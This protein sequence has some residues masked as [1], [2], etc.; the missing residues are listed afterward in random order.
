VHHQLKVDSRE[1]AELFPRMVWHND[2]PLDFANSVQIYA[3]SK[4]AKERV[5][6]VLTGE[7]SDELFGGYPRYRIPDL[8]NMVRYVP[9]PLRRLT[10]SLGDHRVKKLAR[11][12]AVTPDEAILYNASYLRPEVVA[13]VLGR[14]LPAALEYRHE[15]LKATEDLGL[16]RV[17]R[18]SLHDQETFLVGILHRQ[19][20]MSMAASIESRVPFMDYRM[21]EFANRLPSEF[22]IRNGSNKAI[23]KDVAREFLP[24]EIVDRRKSGFGVPLAAWFRQNDGLG[25]RVAALPDSPFAAA[26]DKATLGRLVREHRSGG[27]DHS[28]LLWTVLNLATWREAFR[29]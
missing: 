21:V 8:A 18:V 22:K 5:T 24:A 10:A 13:S 28:E 12:A 19:D 4:L 29:C 23:V 7:G 3:L 25:A 17:Q 16:D 14:V 9:G 20:K 11:Y 26:F 15:T 6:V 27:H 1:Y 2:E